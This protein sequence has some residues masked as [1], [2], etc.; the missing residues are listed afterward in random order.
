M[1]W[2]RRVI[3]ILSVI[4]ALTGTSLAHAASKASEAAVFGQSRAEAMQEMV[5]L[6]QRLTATAR[7]VERVTLQLTPDELDVLAR[8]AKDATNRLRV[9]VHRN[10]SIASAQRKS[11][12]QIHLNGA[13]SIRLVLSDVQGSVAVFNENGQARTYDEDGYTHTF[14]GDRVTIRGTADV[15]GIGAINLADNLCSFNASCVENAEF[16]IIPTAIEAVRNAYASL[17]YSSGRYYY[18]CTGGLIADGDTNSQVPY[19][20]TANHCISKGSEAKSM[21][22]F[23]QFTLS[24]G[25]GNASCGFPASDTV[26]SSIVATNRT[27]DYT[28]LRL[29]QNPPSDSVY[30]G[31]TTDSVATSAGTSLFRISHPGGAPQAYSEHTVD[32]QTGTCRTWPRGSWIYS[33]D[34]F[35][36][37]EGGSTGSPVLNADGQVVGQL[38]G[39]CGF[40]VSDS[41]DA[42]SNATVD[43]A[44]ASYFSEVAAFLDNGGSGGN[45][46]EQCDNLID[47]DND[48]LIDCADPDCDADAACPG[49]GIC[50]DSDN[51]GWCVEDGD[52]N[53]ADP[54]INPGVPDRGGRKWSDNIDNN[55]NGV[56]DG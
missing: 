29:S 30:L 39:A 54:S 5:A 15:T 14:A 12:L 7:Q 9:G 28:L 33:R 38:S 56:I 16:S 40:N 18:V 48:G 11:D 41:C 31:W 43:G 47:D 4:T 26:G 20:L 55:C 51:D 36:A 8:P 13:P 22:T 1:N 19:L 17:L 45:D 49:T 52:C 6:H 23:F 2:F 10:V 32:T 42:V 25:S 3:T 50:T 46:P 34:T 27:G 21:E 53:D 44:F 24:D 35:G 37:T